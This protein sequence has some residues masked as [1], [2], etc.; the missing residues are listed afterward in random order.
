M[1]QDSVRWVSA[2]LVGLAVIALAGR[3]DAAVVWTATLEKGDLS[4]WMPGVNATKGT[5]QNVEVL[6]EQVHTGKFACKITVHPDDTFNG[7]DCVD[8]QH[9]S[10][11]TAEGKQLWLSGYYMMP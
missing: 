4:E 2:P 9:Q 5:R 11:L 10:T 7:Q 1:R 8:I 6:G 3:A